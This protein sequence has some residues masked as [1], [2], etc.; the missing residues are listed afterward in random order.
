[1]MEDVSRR[2]FVQGMSLLALGAHPLLAQVRALA[3]G[4]PLLVGTGSGFGSNS[5]G[6]YAYDFDS[7]SGKLTQLGLAA[8]ADNATF[9]ALSPNQQYLY[10]VN[11]ISFWNGQPGGAVS[12]FAFAKKTLGLHQ[13]SQ[14]SS[15]GA[16]PTHIAVDHTGRCV[17]TANYGS[18][19]VSSY[20]TAE[21]VLSGVVSFFQYGPPPPPF[22]AG[23]GAH[24]PAHPS[25]GPRPKRSHPHRVTPSPDNRFLL[26]NDLGFDQIHVFRLDSKSAV[27]T[28][29]HPPAWNSDPGAGPRALRFHPNGKWVYCVCELK[30]YVY[31]LEWD[32][33]KGTLT[34]KQRVSLV[35][36]GFECNAPCLT[37]T[38]EQQRTI[39]R[40]WQGKSAPDD[41]VW[42]D[43]ARFAYIPSRLYNF[44]VTFRMSATTGELSGMQHSPVG[45]LRP[46]HLAIDP[47]NNWL[48]VANQTSGNLSVIRRNRRT[49]ELSDKPLNFPLG[50]PEC[51]LFV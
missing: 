36:P 29:N 7:D 11:E 49:G 32:A 1:M 42:D 51:V 8:A 18:G 14:V 34:T 9:L 47:S 30:P 5:R 15:R 20:R 13:L 48:V 38:P 43:E 50:G 21:G 4:E 3:K 19:S 22:H 10:A 12:S 2:R 33:D 24:R 25:Q 35:P 45:G 6:I 40:G 31:V 44:M 16:G 46:R 17:F 41:I 28:P 37:P 39:D 26:V 27:L 23:Q